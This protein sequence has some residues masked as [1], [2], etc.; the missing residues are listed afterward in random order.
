LA[1]ACP[2]ERRVAIDALSDI[3]TNGSRGRAK[4]NLVVLCERD[5]Q[6]IGPSD[7]DSALGNKLQN[8]V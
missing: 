8:F 7:G 1:E 4:H 6:S 2:G 3:W 5:G